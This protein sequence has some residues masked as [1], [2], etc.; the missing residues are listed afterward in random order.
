MPDVWLPGVQRE[1]G[2]NAG[3]TNGRT[4][5]ERAVAHFTVGYD[6]RGGGR[7]GYYNFL[8]HRD[9]SREGGCTQYAEVDALTWHAGDI[10]NPYGPGIEWERMTTGGVNDESLSN[11][12]PLTDNQLAWGERII[13]FLAE[14]GIPAQLYDGARYEYGDWRGWI[15]HHDLDSDRSDGL[16]RAEWD[17]MVSHRFVSEV[18]AANE[19]AIYV[20]VSTTPGSRPVVVDPELLECY[21][22]ADPGTA[23]TVMVDDSQRSY[24]IDDIRAKAA[25]KRVLPGASIPRK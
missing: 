5:M 11:A 8:V 10:G 7:D 24:I 12:E 1:A 6:S 14:W 4:T 25:A 21:E 16:L 9:A 17:A 13:A 22:V 3:Y 19:G 15:N 18:V 2:F 20:M 23:P